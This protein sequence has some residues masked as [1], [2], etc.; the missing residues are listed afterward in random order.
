MNGIEFVTKFIET[1]S[2][3]V[4]KLDPKVF[5]LNK[6]FL[7]VRIGQYSGKDLIQEI[8]IHFLDIKAKRGRA[9]NPSALER[10]TGVI[11]IGLVGF[12]SLFIGQL[13][14]AVPTMKKP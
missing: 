4:K 10:A 6:K 12:K 2:A 13:L 14:S 11:G 3:V 1:A 5:Y 8:L 9:F 7:Q